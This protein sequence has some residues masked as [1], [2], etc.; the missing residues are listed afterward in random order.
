M[1]DDWLSIIL[2]LFTA[3]RLADILDILVV[4]V[5]V[6]AALTRLRQARSRFVIY[7]A[8][9]LSALYLVA[10][11]LAMEVTLAL[12]R[13]GVT[14]AAIALVVI[15]QEEIRRIFE[16]LSSGRAMRWVQ[17][18][19]QWRA[20]ADTVV[21]STATLAEG[22]V[23]ALFVF[24]GREPLERHLTGG[25]EL[26]GVLSAP[27]LDSLFDDRTA[28][29][30]GAV[31]IE[32]GRASRFGVHLPLST[33]RETAHMG[34]RHTAA[35]G[36]SERSDALVVVVSEERGEISVARR[37]A[38]TPVASEELRSTL[39]AFFSDLYPTENVS[40]LRRALTHAPAMKLAS[41][42]IA[43]AAWVLFAGVQGQAMSQSFD[44]PIAF[45]NLPDGLLLDAPSPSSATVALSGT[46]G[47]FERLDPARL[48]IRL[49]VSGVSSGSDRMQLH[50]AMVE[51]PSGIDVVGIEPAY[52]TVVGY[53]AMVQ[54][55]PVQPRTQ[56]RLERGLL[57]ESILVSPEKVEAVIRRLDRHRITKLRTPTVDLSRLRE[58]STLT[59][60]LT[61]PPNVHRTAATPETVE[62][63]VTLG[64][65]EH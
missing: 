15:F 25:H 57:L 65:R 12:F 10:R 49:D 4:A 52:T 47:A 13:F 42:A 6:H 32:D 46:R 54:K 55:L 56:G 36:L 21:D 27:L 45:Q 62:V 17:T 38:L 18:P 39:E 7:G 64:R 53:E 43:V 14:I 20:L 29:H 26:D 34:T 5:F 2:R 60:P 1:N 8:I 37:G 19:P 28:G 9:P 35:V 24:R 50:G 3:P 40:R 22:K 63:T 59:L 58:T 16:R 31:I 33:S 11:L 44:V 48:L 61:L 41:L 51:R 30:D 23:G